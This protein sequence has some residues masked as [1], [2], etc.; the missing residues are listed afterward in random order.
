MTSV[1]RAPWRAWRLCLAVVGLCLAVSGQARADLAFGA[2][3]SLRLGGVPSEMATGD[4]NEDGRPDLVVVDRL[5]STVKILLNTGGV[6]GFPRRE[7]SAWALLP[8]AWRR[9]ISMVTGIWM[10]P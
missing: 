7:H 4:F 3:T 2:A 1:A 8:M 6:A 9:R 5:G 10:L